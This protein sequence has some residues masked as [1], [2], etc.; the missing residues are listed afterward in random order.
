M[1][2]RRRSSPLGLIFQ[3]RPPL[4]VRGGQASAARPGGRRPNPSAPSSEPWR[5]PDRP[6]LSSPPLPLCLPSL[7]RQLL[8][9]P[10]ADLRA[11]AAS[12]PPPLPPPAPYHGGGRIRAARALSSVR[13]G[14]SEEQAAAF[15]FFGTKARRCGERTGRQFHGPRRASS[16]TRVARGV[17]GC[18]QL[19]P[20]MPYSI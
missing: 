11:A 6:S 9:A 20:S 1:G 4:G 17:L 19:F 2:I 12:P 16:K 18:S 10:C 8:A 3:Q 14:G 5:R 15:F 7:P 13:A